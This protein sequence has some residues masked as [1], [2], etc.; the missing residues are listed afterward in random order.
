MRIFVYICV[1]SLLGCKNNG[2]LEQSNSQINLEFNKQFKQEHHLFLNYYFGMSVAD[3]E[4]ATQLNFTHKEILLSGENDDCALHRFNHKHTLKDIQEINKHSI[5]YYEF[6]LGKEEFEAVVKPVFRNDKLIR[7]ELQTLNCFTFG[8]HSHEFYRRK[9]NNTRQALLQMH[10]EKYGA[11]QIKRKVHN[12]S[13][14]NVIENQGVVIK[15]FDTNKYIFNHNNKYITIEQK[16][17][18]FKPLVIYTYEKN[19]LNI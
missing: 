9:I 6:N 15:N 12:Q 11:Y 8:N 13:E 1:L 2:P 16:C 10:I 14:K 5:V 17:C 18:D 4:S 3:Y 19:S 7:I